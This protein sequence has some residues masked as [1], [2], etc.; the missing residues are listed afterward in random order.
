M[1]ENTSHNAF[2]RQPS[3]DCGADLSVALVSPDEFRRA[4]AVESA[5]DLCEFSSYLSTP[6]DLARLANMNYDVILVDVDGDTERA[7]KLV[8]TLISDPSNRVLVYS[9]DRSPE[10]L[11]RCMHVGACDFIAFPFERSAVME[12]FARLLAEGTAASSSRRYSAWRSLFDA[13]PLAR[14]HAR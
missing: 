12:A 13:Q 4:A 2:C 6:A 10:M 1:I 14:S 7:L 8:E 3:S 9:S 5:A 11:T